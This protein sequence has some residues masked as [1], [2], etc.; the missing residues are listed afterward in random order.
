MLAEDEVAHSTKL[1]WQKVLVIVCQF[2]YDQSANVL[3]AN[4]F[5]LADLLCKTVN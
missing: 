3:S 1:W 2:T 5:I 4:K